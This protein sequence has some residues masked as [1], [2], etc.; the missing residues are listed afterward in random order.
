MAPV[1]SSSWILLTMGDRPDALA[2]AIESIPEADADSTEIVVV[3]NGATGIEVPDHVRLVELDANLG[4]AAG[5]N[6]GAAAA[7]GDIL[8]FLDD[9][10]TVA[11]PT[12]ARR[13]VARFASEPDLA[14][15]SFRIADPDT[16]A[17]SRRHVPR[18]GRSD[19]L[20]SSDTTSF[21]GGACAIRAAAFH[22]VGGLPEAFFY[23]LEE[24]DLAWR[25]IDAGWRVSYDADAVIHH[26]RTEIARHG[27]ATRLTAR[28]RVL[29]GRRL[30]PIPLALLYVVDWFVITALRNR[31]VAAL[32]DHVA[33]TREGVEAAVERTPISWRTVWRL[34]TLGRPPII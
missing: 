9:D 10:A 30:L 18:L 34:T 21:L 33:G 25:L 19:P 1:D 4:V 15:V 31:S 20:A 26:P 29:L 17:T 3:A 28:N 24:T 27:F 16:G 8:F 6:A 5:R 11:D 12:L 23:A 14:V 13:T 7:T 32:R 2:E 22:A